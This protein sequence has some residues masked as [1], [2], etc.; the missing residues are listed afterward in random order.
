VYTFV[1][2]DDDNDG[3]AVGEEVFDMSSI[4]TRL[5]TDL[6]GIYAAQDPNDF[7]FE[8]SVAGSPITLGSDYTATTGDQIEVK[9]TN[10]LYPVCEET[11]TIDFVVN[12]LPSFD[13]DDTTVIC[14]NLT[15]PVEIGTSNWNGAAD[16]SIYTY[17]WTLD[18]DPSF[19]EATETI[20]PVKGGIY[21]VVVEDPITFCTQTK[22]ITVTESDIASIDLD[23]DGDITDTEYDHFIEVLDLTDDNTNTIKINNVAD[24]GIGDY[25]FSL[26]NINYQPD[27][28]F[29][30]LDPGVYT[31]YIRD[32]NSYYSYTYGCGI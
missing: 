7:D 28:E 14:L 17:S 32:K 10:P 8:Y 16:P 12:P 29:T 11:I 1:E 19:S 26:D 4:T 25:E 13:I 6:N 9:I 3:L 31:L 18:S 5:L 23:N 30:D 21:T 22:S 27:N 15:Q 24:L 2:C 20:F